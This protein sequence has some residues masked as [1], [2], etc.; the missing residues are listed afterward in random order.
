MGF[1]FYKASS[2]CLH[3]GFCHAAR[4][5][6]LGLDCKVLAVAACVPVLDIALSYVYDLSC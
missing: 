3:Q 5:L 1:V 4:V 2:G 6:I